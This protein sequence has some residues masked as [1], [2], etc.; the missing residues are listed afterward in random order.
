MMPHM[1][2][3]FSVERS[4]TVE[5]SVHDVYGHIVDL[6]KWN[7][8]SP[9]ADLDPAMDQQFTGPPQGTGQSM[10]WKGNRKVGMGSMTITDAKPDEKV[11]L[12]LTFLKPFIATNTVD[13]DLIPRGRITE[14]QWVMR[15]EL[16]LVM[17]AMNKVKPMDAMLGPDFE[18]GLANLKRVSE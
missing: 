15:G 1:A 11:S 2:K 17:Q 6:K 14:V 3:P 10:A 7:A 9:W 18:R 12:D 5:A 4:V 16:N 8:W 13:I